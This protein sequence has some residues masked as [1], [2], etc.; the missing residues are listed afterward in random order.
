MSLHLNSLNFLN[1]NPHLEFFNLFCT[2]LDCLESPLLLE[3]RCIYKKWI[4]NQVASSNNPCNLME[5][6]ISKSEIHFYHSLSLSCQDLSIWELFTNQFLSLI[7]LKTQI[8][9]REVEI[10]VF[11]N[12]CLEFHI[13][14]S[15]DKSNLGFLEFY[16]FKE[17]LSVAKTESIR[18]FLQLKLQNLIQNEAFLDSMNCFL[19]QL[20]KEWMNSLLKCI[21][22]SSKS[23]KSQEKENEW[24][25]YSLIL[26]NLDLYS[27]F[28]FDL[29]SLI[30]TS[31]NLVY[32]MSFYLEKDEIEFETVE[33]DEKENQKTSNT[34][35]NDK[36]SFKNQWNHLIKS[37]NENQRLEIQKR[38][39]KEL[40]FI[41]KSEC[42]ELFTLELTCFIQF[43]LHLQV[44]R[45]EVEE[46]CL[47]LELPIYWHKDLLVLYP[48]FMNFRENSN[49][50]VIE[51]Q[52]KTLGL[53][54]LVKS[55]MHLCLQDPLNSNCLLKSD[56]LFYL[57]MY[58]YFYSCLYDE[59]NPNSCIL[60]EKESKEF[61]NE[62][63]NSFKHFNQDNLYHLVEIGWDKCSQGHEIECLVFEF[64]LKHSHLNPI[65]ILNR[66]F[67]LE[68]VFKS[69]K[70]YLL[71]IL[72]QFVP[73]KEFLNYISYNDNLQIWM[74]LYL[75]K[76]NSTDLSNLT[77]EMSE[78]VEKWIQEFQ[79]MNE[80]QEN[81]M[82]SKLLLILSF[83]NSSK[84]S[85]KELKD[86]NVLEKW[87]FQ[88][89]QHKNPSLSCIYY[90]SQL[91]RQLFP[92]STQFHSLFLQFY[93]EYGDPLRPLTGPLRQIQEELI[94]WE[95]PESIIRVSNDSHV[96]E[97]LS[98]LLYSSNVSIQVF[99]THLLMKSS[100]IQIQEWNLLIE[101][102]RLTVNQ[103][104]LPL[105]CVGNIL[106][107]SWEHLQD[108]LIVMGG[109]LLSW[110]ILLTFIKDA[111][112]ELKSK[113]I[114]ELR[115]KEVLNMFMSLLNVILLD[116][117]LSEFSEFSEFTKGDS[118]KW[119]VMN[120]YIQAF[121]GSPTSI[122][123]LC[124][125]IYYTLLITCPSLVRIWWTECKNRQITLAF[126]EFT[127]KYYSHLITKSLLDSLDSHEWTDLTIKTNKKNTVYATFQI[128]DSQ[129]D[130]II[131]FPNDY[132]LRQV[133]I[134]QGLGKIPGV[135][136]SKWRSWLLQSTALLVSQN[137]SLI[138]ALLLFKK[139]VDLHFQGV[140]D[141]AI[142]YSIIGV[143]DNTIPSKQCKNCKHKFHSACLFKWFNISQQSTCPLCRQSSF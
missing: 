83:K 100:A 62:L 34:L 104:D 63:I 49:Q 16:Y 60:N 142:C 39:F 136:E 68:E 84:Y 69:K 105:E 5:K 123:L 92:Q 133:E 33:K 58:F 90:S 125:H 23:Y 137:A 10:Q 111:T 20:S 93:I 4:E 64:I 119:D 107:V 67:H 122:S 65:S 134:Q 117:T 72:T 120:Y 14:F 85:L 61:K 35:L 12:Y 132:P 116:P 91:A 3:T 139:N 82:E 106:N 44:K 78:F 26:L 24:I 7:S 66:E 31:V 86:L 2:L 74:N 138:D 102:S 113:F 131:T 101:M 59:M 80:N 79:E 129:L 43:I 127:M 56:H 55:T 89:L 96:F 30:Q 9:S 6:C 51:N 28:S 41:L 22:D 52:D 76:G 40:I 110:N 94:Q 99:S 121:D 17:C 112:F 19:I 42:L 71:S 29:N 70:S 126:Q 45:E 13:S 21:L 97:S 115:S 88:F 95:F 114:S 53:H 81:L 11:L 98:R 87:I 18:L 128:E 118:S 73:W 36:N 75:T 1:G 25:L 50:I 57:W 15:L 109:Y 38:M 108:D 124:S 130:L 143:M 37:L 135:V 141:C 48:Q 54:R 77:V 46:L 140:E 103:V 47:N 27:L 8:D 32:L